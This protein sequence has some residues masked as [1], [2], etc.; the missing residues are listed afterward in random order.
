M[1]DIKKTPLYKVHKDLGG[2]IIDFS[3]WALPVQYGGIISEHQAVR[4]FAG[5][6]DVSHMGEIEISGKDAGGFVQ[7]L[8]TNDISNLKDH[9]ILYTPMCNENGGIIDD[10]LVYKFKESHYLLVVNA[11]NIDKDWKWIIN[12]KKGY[13]VYLDD[14]SNEISLIALQGPKAE[15]ILGKLVDID[16]SKLRFFYFEPQVNIQGINA[17]VSRTGYTGEDGFE[18]YCSNEDVEKLWDLLLNAGREF[19]LQP[20]GLGARDTLRFEAGLPLYG[21]EIGEDISP[22][23]GGLSYFVKLDKGDFIGRD[24]LEKQ[25]EEGLKRKLVGI[26]LEKGI[27]RQAYRVLREGRPVGEITTGYRSPSLNTNIAMA[28]I[29]TD[30]AIQGQEIQ[31]EIREKVFP[32]RVVSKNFY[33]RKR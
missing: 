12:N 15:A 22:L 30:H 28:L 14:R 8:I 9:Q 3:G 23:E 32:G 21:N 13:N 17:L 18:I 27:P 10:L 33:K 1:E 7:E 19:G 20:A 31:V 2:K 25:R 5:L 6:F 4:N 11:A 26:E 24:A 29:E 16:L